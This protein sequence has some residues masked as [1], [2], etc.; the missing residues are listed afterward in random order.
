MNKRKIVIV[1]LL[2]I[3]VLLIGFSIYYSMSNITYKTSNRP[4]NE[5]SLNVIETSIDNT[6]LQTVTNEVIAKNIIEEKEETN[7][8]LS[9]SSNTND[10]EK[11]STS[12]TVEK[13][14]TTD[15]VK[16]TNISNSSNSTQNTR[17]L[18]TTTQ[19]QE[20]ST[21]KVTTTLVTADTSINQNTKEEKIEH[22][23]LAYTTY[24]E[25]N[26][27]IVPEIIN[28][29]N[30][31][32]SKDKELVDFGSKAVAGNKA[33]AYKNTT[34]FTYMFANKEERL[35][36]R[37]INNVGAFGTYFVYA[38][39]EYTYNSSG[40]NPIWSQTLVWIWVSF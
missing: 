36:Q 19:S 5:V 35:T 38:E 22:P 30:N 15:N 4:L 32:I 27:A 21:Q 20:V 24:R 18:Q 2:V 39:D 29:L 11:K 31:E 1:I 26:T 10:S 8:T 9:I 16:N 14:T 6:I 7:D 25:R 37:V 13:S 34:G 28:I 33:E 23:E 17:S 40:T 3:I 12:T